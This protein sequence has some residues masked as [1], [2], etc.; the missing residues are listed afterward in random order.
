MG[1]ASVLIDSREPSW[2]QQLT[3]GGVP[4]AVM[5]LDA[6]DLLLTADDGAILAI[7]RKTASDF[8]NS[9]HDDRLF[10]QVATLY[11]VTPWSYLVLTRD[12]RPGPN[13]KAIADGRE[14]GWTWPSVQGA[15]VTVQE[16]GV[17]VVQVV[18]DYDYEATVIRLAN[19]NREPVWIL[20]PRDALI[21]TEAEQILAAL[22]GIGVE[23]ARAVLD[24][25]GSA[26][27]AL[28]F[29]TDDNC[30]PE[31]KIG[32]AEGTKRR[33]RKALGLEDWAIL[34]PL[35]RDGRPVVVQE[36]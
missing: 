2:V 3:F 11:A 1:L 16:L 13:G 17:H 25:C 21:V 26:A 29:L 31:A 18:S 30:V 22:P 10:A 24:Y 6:G 28:A 19:R 12:L 15:L 27:W 23:R 9:L 34:H 35:Q 32:I 36:V 14:S 8:L 7:E 4:T 5:Q 20:P 33:V